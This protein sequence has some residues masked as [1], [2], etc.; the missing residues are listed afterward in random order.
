LR[1]IIRSSPLAIFTLDLNGT[2]RSW[3]HAAER[4]F[5][6]T[7]EEVVNQP[8]PLFPADR[9]PE[10]ADLMCRLTR[11]ETFVGFESQRRRKDGTFIE[12]SI[13]AA[14]LYD[15]T[16]QVNGVMTLMADITDIKKAERALLEERALLRGLI[17]SIPDHIFYKD[18]EGRY[19]GCNAAFEKFVGRPEKEIVGLTFSELFPER[20]PEPHESIDRQI[21]L[22]GR[23]HRLEEWITY[24]DNRR[25]LHEVIKSPFLG[26]DGQVRG[27]IGMSRDITERK[28]L[29]EGL[30][31]AQKMEAVGQL[32][33][34]VAHDFNNLLT[35]ILGNVS[36]ILSNLSPDHPDRDLLR[37]TER[38]ATR[39]AELTGQLLGFSRKALLRLEPTNLN[40]ALDEVVSILRRTI[41]PRITVE[42]HRAPDLSPVLADMGRINQVLM[43]L[44][45]NARDAMPD[46]GRLT[47]ETANVTVGQ[48]HVRRH[49]DAR[50]GQ[51]VRLRV[52]DTGHGIPVDVRP[53]IF[54][55]FFTTKPPGQGT[56]LGL[57]MV[58]GIVQQHKGWVECISEPGQGTDFEIYLPC[59]HEAPV[60]T[61]PVAPSAPARGTETILLVDDEAVIR[62]LGRTVLQ[63]HGYRVLLAEDGVEAV[64]IYRRE[65]RDIDL[66]ILDLTMPRLSGRDTLRQLREFDPGVRVLYS[67]GYTSEQVP[68]PAKEGVLGFVN[69]PYRPQELVQVVRQVLDQVR[70]GRR[71]ISIGQG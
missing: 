12:A 54:E 14:P 21:I 48:A 26:P 59:S 36:L 43:N 8:T 56:G 35:A 69:K 19:L 27:L 46:G 60:P 6:W 9:A 45:L 44:C 66:V 34:G 25:L 67:S 10:F 70:G 16:G 20:N 4:L 17:D 23:P 31:Q 63:R 68:E 15:A 53:R 51:F 58:F 65:Y 33:G 41:D 11:G 32:A 1:A 42:V 22:D 28:Q 39:A 7:E 57:A 55:P 13:S 37:D 71:P 38:A 40:L 29:E 47:L 18:R 64:A 49:M 50:I 24:P 52:R 3:N 62:N 61:V 5:G 30:R 2:I